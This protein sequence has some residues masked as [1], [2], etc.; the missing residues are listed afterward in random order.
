M[1]DLCASARHRVEPGVAHGAEYVPH[2]HVVL[3][4]VVLDLDGGVALDVDVGTVRLDASHELKVV[5]VG[6]IRIE[7]IDD[8]NLSH[9]VLIKY[10]NSLEGVLEG[11]GPG[12]L[13][14][15]FESR[16]RAE[17]AAGFADV[18]GVDVEVAVEPTQVAVQALTDF[19]GQC[20]HR[21]QQC[22]GYS[23]GNGAASPY[24]LPDVGPWGAR[25]RV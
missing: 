4:G 16:E 14:A 21:D 13:I 11:H 24:R 1:E 23:H 20:A 10:S 6:Q 7:P 12:V 22:G 17:D 19:I 15:G 25:D 9:E 2:R 8:V 18:G 5:V 3:V